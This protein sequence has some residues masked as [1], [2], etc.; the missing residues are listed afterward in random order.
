MRKKIFHCFFSFVLLSIVMAHAEE[1]RNTVIGELIKLGEFYLQKK[2]YRM[3]IRVLTRLLKN[4]PDTTFTPKILKDIGEAY[5]GVGEYDEALK[6]WEELVQ[7]YSQSDEAPIALQLEINVLISLG[8]YS[9]AITKIDEFSFRYPQDENTPQILFKKGQC[10]EAMGELKKALEEFEN[11]IK[12]F[13]QHPLVE[14]AF[15]KVVKI[16]VLIATKP[17]PTRVSLENLLNAVN[18]ITS[19]IILSK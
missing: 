10:Y 8:K 18:F 1:N 2:C 3:S 5:C 11:F 4:Y 13:P 12:H 14:K 7:K 16:A 17:S 6:Y 15:Q 19:L 9:E